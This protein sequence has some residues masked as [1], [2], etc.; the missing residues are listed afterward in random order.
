MCMLQH[1]PS[2]KTEFLSQVWD[3]SI[4]ETSEKRSYDSNTEGLIN[5]IQKNIT[6]TWADQVKTWETCSR[7]MTACPDI[8]ATESIKA[9]CNWAYKGVSEGSVLEDDYFLSRLPIVNMRLA[10]GG[11]RLAATLN[12]VFG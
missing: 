12:R 1:F 6:T 8:Y 2:A 4:I 10:Q 3:D 11:V 5:A 7:N 9:A